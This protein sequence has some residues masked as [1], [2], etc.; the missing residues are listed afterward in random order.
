VD[1]TDLDS[2]RT[3]SGSDSNSVSSDPG[4]V[5]D[6][7]LHVTSP[8]VDSMGTP[9]AEVVDDIDGEAR[10]PSF[11]DIGADEFTPGVNYPPAITSEPETLAYV[12]SLYQYQVMATDQNGD[13]L[14][15]SLSVAPSWLTIDDSTGLIE[16]IPTPGDLGDTTVTVLVD[17]GHGGSDSQTYDLHVLPPIGIESSD[18]QGPRRS[19]LLQNFPNPF[20]PTTRIRFEIPKSAHVS[21]TVYNSL[22]TKVA[23][24][25]D[26]ELS[27]GQH[28]TQWNA[29]DVPTGVYYYRLK[30]EVFARTGKMLVIH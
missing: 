27:G 17:D 18:S 28:E 19:T 9:L 10:D 11:P 21:L 7:D 12:D 29:G 30:T 2:L 20:H 1:I 22:G 6:F 25:V 4:F 14:I 26:E 23:T 24:L 13:T 16:G 15:Y 5:S 3:V 8:A